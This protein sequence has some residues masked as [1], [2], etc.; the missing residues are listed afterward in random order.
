M[1]MCISLIHWEYNYF[2]H[3]HFDKIAAIFTLVQS[4]NW[5]CMVGF[6]FAQEMF[7][8]Q[9]NFQHF[10]IHAL[11]SLRFFMIDLKI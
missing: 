9:I 3:D 8:T 1:Q 5:M 11:N 10:T 2:K 4:E 7:R 6:V